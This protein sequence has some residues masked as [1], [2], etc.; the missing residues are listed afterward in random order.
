MTININC[1]SLY[2]NYLG[3][4]VE[5]LI[6]DETQQKVHENAQEEWNFYIRIRQHAFFKYP[7]HTVSSKLRVAVLSAPKCVHFL[8]C[9]QTRALISLLCESFESS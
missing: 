3:D 5:K 8:E 6:V 9:S 1:V 7:G 2:P 4:Q